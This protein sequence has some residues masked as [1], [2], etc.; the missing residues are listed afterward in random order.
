MKKLLCALG[1][2]SSALIVENSYSQTYV[3]TEN[4]E[5]NYREL[6]NPAKELPSIS[7]Y[8]NPTAIHFDSLDEITKKRTWTILANHYEMQVE[9]Y[10]NKLKDY[11]ADKVKITNLEGQIKTLNSDKSKLQADLQN[12]NDILKVNDL[13]PKE[14][15]GKGK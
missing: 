8:T 13:L 3:K 6:N 1:I 14:E 10:E 4:V 7:V 2:V 9:Q 12:C 5:K 11:E 15:K